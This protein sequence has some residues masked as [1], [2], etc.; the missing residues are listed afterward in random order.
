MDRT[1]STKK[2]NKNI[3]SIIIWILDC[4]LS[5]VYIRILNS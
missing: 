4:T 1:E 2:I 3:Y 5:S